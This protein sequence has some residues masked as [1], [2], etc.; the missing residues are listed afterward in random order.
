MKKT[1]IVIGFI[2]V[3][4]GLALALYLTF[5]K[6]KPPVIEKPPEEVVVPRLPVSREDWERMTIEERE[7]LGLPAMEWPEGV[8]EIIPEEPVPEEAPLVSEIALG[9]LTW[10][11]PISLEATQNAELARDGQ[12]AVYYQKESGRFYE[13]APDGTKKLLT[14]QVFFNVEKVI[15]SPVKDKAILEYPDGFKTV[16]DFQKKKVVSLPK[17]WYDF[18]FNPSGREIVFKTDSKYPE[19]RWLAM[20]QA[21]GTN[22]KVIEHMGENQDKVIVDWSPNYQV[23][24]FARTGEP[25]GAFEQEILLIGRY[26][27]D[28][29]PL[30]VDGQGFESR[31]SPLGD[32]I[33][34]SVYSDK[35]NYNPMLYVVEAQGDRIGY[36]KKNLGLA[37]WAHK[38]TFNQNGETLYCAV[39]RDLPQGSS[40]VPELAENVKDDFYQ[41]DLRTGRASFLAE[42]AFGAYRVEKMFLSADEKLLYFVDQDTGRLHYLRLK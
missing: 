12:S 26:G 20:A 28:F 40:L 30:V 8:A 23:I 34:Y 19:D 10:T 14:D 24:A 35:T 38:C 25:R 5:F 22:A 2:L 6:P 18:S 39:P 21:D 27:E 37:T 16:Y 29:R 33:V 41:V 13:I 1:L 42:G 11:Y 3:T 7:R 32:K 31:W 17:E 9:G 15:W 36:G 4:I